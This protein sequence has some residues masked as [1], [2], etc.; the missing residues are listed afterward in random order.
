MHVGFVLFRILFYS[1]IILFDLYD[2]KNLS[3]AQENTKELCCETF[4]DEMMWCLWF[5]PKNIP[6]QS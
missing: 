2:H 3:L 5:S 6:W 1:S 4:I